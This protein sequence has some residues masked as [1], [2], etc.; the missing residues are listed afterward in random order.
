MIKLRRL[1]KVLLQVIYAIRKIDWVLFFRFYSKRSS[2]VILPSFVI[3]KFGVEL[4]C[5]DLAYIHALIDQ[6]K[7]FRILFKP[8]KIADKIIYWSPSK[9]M[10]NN[11][12]GDYAKELIDFAKK[13]ESKNNILFPSSHDVSFLENK[14]YMYDYFAN[15]NIRTPQTYILSNFNEINNLV[16]EYPLLL[17]GEHSAGS[18][19]VFKFDTKSALQDFLLQSS[20]LSQYKHIILQQLLNIRRDLRVTLV[21]NEIVLFYWRINPA[22]EWRPTAS[23]Y[24]SDIFFKDFPEKWTNYIIKAFEKTGLGMGAFDVCWQNDDLSTEPYFLEVS[25]RFSPNPPIDLSGSGI[26]YAKWKKKLIGNEVYYKLQTNEI[27]RICKKYIFAQQNI[28]KNN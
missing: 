28:H 1:A 3:G 5:W 21:N 20:F 10:T 13:C 11:E 12:L 26:T 15:N 23:V 14:A 19:A 27:F 2:T 6:K 24:G 18:E 8:E 9:R 16:L 7:T 25:P 17:K 22:K 4:F